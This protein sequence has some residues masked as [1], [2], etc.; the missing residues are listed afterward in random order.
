MNR[1]E[2]L[3]KIF[4]RLGVFGH[5]PGDI[6][7]ASDLGYQPMCKKCGRTYGPEDVIARIR[8]FVKAGKAIFVFIGMTFIFGIWQWCQLFGGFF[9]FITGG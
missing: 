7:I 8:Y 2:E 3:Q 5:G 6:S 1:I 4:C 9:K